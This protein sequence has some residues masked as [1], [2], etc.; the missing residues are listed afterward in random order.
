[1]L[2]YPARLVPAADGSIRCYIPDVPEAVAEGKN[3][4][5]ALF[6]AVFVLESCLTTY[7][8][9]GRA[10]PVPSHAEGGPSVTTDKFN[11]E[12]TAGTESTSIP[13]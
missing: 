2:S 1:M 6:S 4:E 9:H 5:D 11:L 12:A 10:L 13:G 8:M 3:E 7:V